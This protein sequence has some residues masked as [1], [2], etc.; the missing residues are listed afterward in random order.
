M[1]FD[2][3]RLA[4][5]LRGER[6]A[7]AE[8]STQQ[9]Q[10]QRGQDLVDNTPSGG[11][12]IFSALSGNMDRQRGRELISSTR[13]RLKRATEQYANAAGAGKM[14]DARQ[15]AEQKQYDR[16][17]DTTSDALKAEQQ[18]YDRGQTAGALGRTMAE[19][20]AKRGVE[21]GDKQGRPVDFVNRNDPTDII[22]AFET[23]NQGYQTAEGTPLTDEY[24]LYEEPA[25]EGSGGGRRSPLARAQTEALKQYKIR[26]NADRIAGVAKDFTPAEVKT[27]ED[28]RGR[29]GKSL[30]KAVTPLAFT[31]ILEGE[32]DS[33]TPRIRTFL[34]QVRSGSAEV[35][36]QLFGSAL[37]ATETESSNGFLAGAD[38]LKLSDIMRR[39]NQI[40]KTSADTLNSLDASGGEAGYSF[41]DYNPWENLSGYNTQQLE[42]RQSQAGP[43]QQAALEWLKNNSD[44]PDAPGVIKRLQ[45]EELY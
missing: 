23:K 28:L 21:G 20:R 44:S 38:G 14:Y 25:S 7:K 19:M 18:E 3:N 40:D 30:A 15:Q 31:A 17:R 32:F 35:R 9:A 12:N 8:L 41:A 39:I 42:L 36:N 6:T 11:R 1:E 26:G 34:N 24:K 43:Q 13:P 10:M 5:A 45:D 37:T 4:Q 16:E 2:A 22:T 33:Y 27:L 29:L